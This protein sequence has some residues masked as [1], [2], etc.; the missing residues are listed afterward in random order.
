MS[1]QFLT[2]FASLFGIKISRMLKMEMMS[3]MLVDDDVVCFEIN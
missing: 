3:T 1:D 2:F